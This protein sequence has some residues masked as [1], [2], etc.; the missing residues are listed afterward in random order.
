MIKATATINGKSFVFSADNV[1][2]A[3]ATFWFQAKV[4]EAKIEN[5]TFYKIKHIQL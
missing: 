3:M 5:V 4:L 1:G 2:L